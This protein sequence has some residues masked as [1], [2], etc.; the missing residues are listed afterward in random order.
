MPKVQNECIQG[1]TEPQLTA[2]G[3]MGTPP[4]YMALLEEFDSDCEPPPQQQEPTPVDNNATQREL[5]QALSMAQ[6]D[7]LLLVAMQD[8]PAV[9]AHAATLTD[10]SSTAQVA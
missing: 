4:S 5:L 8:Y 3:V 9:A 6:K 10:Q 2:I 7:A 1:T